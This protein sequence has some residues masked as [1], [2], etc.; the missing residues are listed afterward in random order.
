[1]DSIETPILPDLQKL[2]RFALAIGLVLLTY[3]LAAV[4][5]DTGEP[6][7]LLIVPLK[8][9]R[10]EWLP[11]GLVLASL[12]AAARYW[13]YGISIREAPW[14]LRFRFLS[15]VKVKKAAKREEPTS[16]IGTN[17]LCE[18]LKNQALSVFPGL[19]NDS[20]VI[21]PPEGTHKEAENRWRLIFNEDPTADWRTFLHDVDYIAPIL[22]NVFALASQLSLSLVALAEW[23]SGSSTA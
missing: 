22:V 6:I 11:I 20:I 17:D 14:A 18:L 9:D 19:R 4:E 7:R 15:L 8:F 21:M 12:Y 5:L 3:S 16:M 2:R 13:Y 23:L 1:M 10:P